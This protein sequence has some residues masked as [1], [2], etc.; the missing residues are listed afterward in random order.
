M[1]TTATEQT[2]APAPV[3]TNGQNGEGQSAESRLMELLRQEE[4]PLDHPQNASPA[5]ADGAPETDDETVTFSDSGQTDLS[6]EATAPPDADE[7]DG[8]ASGEN[9]SSDDAELN[10]ALNG[11][12]DDAKA[13]LVQMA[14][15]IADGKTSLGKLKQG[16]RNERKLLERVAELEAKLNGESHPET[17]VAA[18]ITFRR[19]WQS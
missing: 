6:P 2:A 16:H 13:S 12:N 8:A 1:S 4:T 5:P 7:A 15:E 9:P 10:E 14:K 19:K 17:P 18:P 11:L 3:S